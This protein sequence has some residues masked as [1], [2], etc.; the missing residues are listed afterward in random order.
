M[1][2]LVSPVK[3]STRGLFRDWDLFSLIK[4]LL[5]DLRNKKLVKITEIDFFEEWLFF[6]LKS[7]FQIDWLIS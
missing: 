4:S 7:F 3:G 2:A 5:L 1:Q 6:K